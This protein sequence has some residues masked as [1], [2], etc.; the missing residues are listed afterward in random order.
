M[1]LED[2]PE[3]WWY[4]MASQTVWKA[5]NIL[6]MKVYLARVPNERQNVGSSPMVL[7]VMW[8]DLPANSD[9]KCTLFPFKVFSVRGLVTA[10]W[11][12]T[13]TLATVFSYNN[14]CKGIEGVELNQNQFQLWESVVCVQIS[15]WITLNSSLLKFTIYLGII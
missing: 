8:Y 6:S 14:L 1:K 10:E 4:Q 13:W 15:S 11:K 2:S 12:V 7:P 9:L 5:E 3:C